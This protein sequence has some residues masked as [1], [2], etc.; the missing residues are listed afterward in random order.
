MYNEEL[1]EKIKEIK[2][3]N[4]I[5]IIYI[6]IIIF[7]F[8]S[9]YLEKNYFLYNDLESKKKYRKSLIIIFSILLVIYYYFLND[10]YNSVKKLN[11]YD[12]N[13]KKELVY[14]SFIGS[15]FIFLSGIIFL[16]VAYKD[17]NIDVEIAFN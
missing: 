5:W 12:S 6:G 4:I 3:E 8:Y 16:Y 13:D 7:S 9:N 15:L 2:T 10:S 17:E 1:E 11:I 14:L